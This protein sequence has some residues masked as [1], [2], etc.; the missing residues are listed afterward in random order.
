MKVEYG[1]PLPCPN[2]KAQIYIVVIHLA[3]GVIALIVEYMRKAFVEVIGNKK[4][5]MLLMFGTSR[6]SYLTLSLMRYRGQASNVS[7]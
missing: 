5:L 2:C 4:N 1:T 6:L 3:A 7:A